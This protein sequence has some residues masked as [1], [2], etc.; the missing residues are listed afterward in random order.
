MFVAF[1]CLS[2]VGV[3]SVCHQEMTPFFLLQRIIAHQRHEERAGK[4][5]NISYVV[6]TYWYIF[7]E[8][9]KKHVSFEFN[10]SVD[11]QLC[12]VRDNR[13]RVFHYV[14]RD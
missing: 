7:Y 11:T 3:S 8:E 9:L 4:V 5:R 10:R 12:K 6:R 13:S 2:F 14:P 1:A